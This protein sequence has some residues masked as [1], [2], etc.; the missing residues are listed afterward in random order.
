MR[1]MG[2]GG[3]D[4]RLHIALIARYSSHFTNTGGLIH[5]LLAFFG[6][7][8]PLGGETCLHVSRAMSSGTRR[9]V[10]V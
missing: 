2:P 6:L 5:L 4:C 7:R 9:E 8:Y 1:S 3:Q 10:R